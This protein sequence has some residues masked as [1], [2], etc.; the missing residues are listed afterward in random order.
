MHLGKYVGELV[1]DLIEAS[2]EDLLYC[3]NMICHIGILFK[4]FIVFAGD[5]E[6]LGGWRRTKSLLLSEEYKMLASLVKGCKVD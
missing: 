3:L 4:I 1:V 2:K 5:A 6:E